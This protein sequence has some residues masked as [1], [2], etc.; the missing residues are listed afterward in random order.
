M[1][2]LPPLA[3]VCAVCLVLAWPAAAQKSKAPAGFEGRVVRVIDGATFV[4]RAADKSEST[5]RLRQIDPPELCQAG[6]PE[7][8]QALIDAAL[9]RNVQVGS[10]SRT[11]AGTLLAAVVLDGVD[12]SRRQV[13][14]GHALS[15]R[16]RY[17][18]GPLVK[19]ERMA[20]ALRRGLHAVAN[21]ETPK[22][23]RQRNGPCAV[24]EAPRAAAAPAVNIPSTSAAPAAPAAPGYRCDGR[25]RCTQMQ[26]CEEARFFLKNCPTT[27][28]D[29]DRDGVPCEDQWCR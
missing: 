17:D 9:G 3:I 15:L 29:G 7:S 20:R 8:K 21:A 27:A 24:S 25:T 13:E 16:V 26:S 4:V 11:P 28:M 6:G 18:N 12:L 23:F 2:L 19:E 1:K 10:A 14:E 22:D 5:V